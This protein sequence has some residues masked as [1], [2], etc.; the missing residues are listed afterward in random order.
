[1]A[2]RT[3]GSNATASNGQHRAFKPLTLAREDR[4]YHGL[5]RALRLTSDTSRATKGT[6]M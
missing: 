5:I 1:M 6:R 2:R 4:M 3:F